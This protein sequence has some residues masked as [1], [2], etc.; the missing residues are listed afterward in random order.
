MFFITFMNLAQWHKA[1]FSLRWRRQSSRPRMSAGP[2]KGAAISRKKS[3]NTILVLLIWNLHSIFPWWFLTLCISEKVIWRQW[4][5]YDGIRRHDVN[6]WERDMKFGVVE[7]E[8]IANK[9][10]PRFL[11]L[12]SPIMKYKVLIL[13]TARKC[14]FTYKKHVS[15][16]IN[17]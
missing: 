15:G 16:Q 8:V 11:W 4:R 7:L 9:R 6:N 12:S 10:S 13:P 14:I 2:L 3:K 5:H 1:S 17:L